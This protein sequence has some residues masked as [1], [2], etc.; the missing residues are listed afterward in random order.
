MDS[1]AHGLRLPSSFPN[2][3]KAKAWI[4]TEADCSAATL[5]SPEEH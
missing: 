1:L 2:S 4:G 5:L 3:R